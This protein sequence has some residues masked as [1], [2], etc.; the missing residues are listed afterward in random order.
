MGEQLIIETE[1]YKYLG[2]ELDKKLTFNQFKERIADKARKN[3]GMGMKGGYLSVRASVNL[4][5]ALVRSNLEYGIQVWGEGKWEGGELIQREMGRRIL[6]CRG[7]TTTEAVRG[8]L[9]WWKLQTRREYAKLKY[10]IGILLME[11]TRLVKQ[12]YNHSRI[13]FVTQRKNN[14]VKIIYQLIQKYGLQTL[15]NDEQV[16]RQARR[17]NR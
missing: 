17:K 12:V 5:E 11:E 1:M 7:N 16:V 13:K 14:W 3:K 8:E 15:W 2:A 4:W 10:W 9:G 6:H